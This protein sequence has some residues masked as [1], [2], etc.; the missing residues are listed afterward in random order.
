MKRAMR[1][2]VISETESEHSRGTG[3]RDSTDAAKFA[4]HTLPL[5]RP[6]E[7]GI[8]KKNSSRSAGDVRRAQPTELVRLNQSSPSHSGEPTRLHQG[9][10]SGGEPSHLEQS[11]S[12]GGESLNN[13]EPSKKLLTTKCRFAKEESDEA[14]SSDSWSCDGGIKLVQ[15]EPV[16]LD[17]QLKGSDCSEPEADRTSFRPDDGVQGTSQQTAQA[18]QISEPAVATTNA[19]SA[20]RN[21]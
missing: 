4:T 6:P 12:A 13:A 20:Q 2:G 3:D 21:S 14:E 1:G 9:S 5:A 8:L 19:S 18:S 15:T 11:I 17:D 10:P 7:K 16:L